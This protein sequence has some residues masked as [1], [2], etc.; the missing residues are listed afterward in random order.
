MMIALKQKY[1]NPTN[2]ELVY[3]HE[4]FNDFLRNYPEVSE[5]GKYYQAK[6][7]Y[8]P[9]YYDG[10][11]GELNALDKSKIGSERKG[12]FHASVSINDTNVAAMID[13]GANASFINEEFL[14]KN[15]IKFSPAPEG[16]TF[17]RGGKVDKP[18]GFVKVKL[19]WGTEEFKDLIFQVIDHKTENVILGTNLFD[20]LK[21]YIAGLPV[22]NPGPEVV[23][24]NQVL[25]GV[26]MDDDNLHE[27]P[28][29]EELDPR[30]Q[31]AI[32]RNLALD[33]HAASTHP[34][35]PLKLDTSKE[36]TCFRPQ[37]YIK[38]AD[39]ARAD[40]IFKEYIEKGILVEGDPNPKACFASL[41]VP[42]RNDDGEQ[43]DI[44][45]CFDLGP[46]NHEIHVDEYPLPLLQKILDVA[47]KHRGP[48]TFRS[49]IDLTGAFNV[50]PVVDSK[51]HTKWNG[52]MY[53]VERGFFGVNILPSHFQRMM[54]AINREHDFDVETYLDDTIN[55]GG[56]KEQ[57]ILQCIEI[58]N[59]FTKYGLRIN[60]KKC[61]FGKSELP[62]L[63][64]YASGNGTRMNPAKVEA[65]VNWKPPKSGLEIAKF[66]GTVNF[67]RKHL[68]HF[69]T[70]AA[71]LDRLRTAH[72]VEW[73]QELQKCFDALKEL[74]IH[75]VTLVREDFTKTP[76]V[77]TDASTE[78][79][80]YWRGQVKDQFRHIPTKDLKPE[81]IEPIEF[82]SQAID[83]KKA[84]IG[85]T[86]RELAA[87]VLALRKMSKNLM[88]RRFAL[89]TDHQPLIWLFNTKHTNSM[90]HRYIDLFLTMTFDVY[91][92]RGEDNIVADA[93]SRPTAIGSFV[94]PYLIETSPLAND[95]VYD[96]PEANGDSIDENSTEINTMEL[97]EDEEE[98]EEDTQHNSRYAA[99]MKDKILP[100]DEEERLDIIEKAHTKGHMGNNQT[101]QRIFNDGYWW[102]TIRA[103]IAKH[104]GAC[105]PCLRFTTRRT[106]YHPLTPIIEQYPGKGYCMDL[107]FLSENEEDKNVLIVM[108]IATG[109]ILDLLP[110]NTK[111]AT[112]IADELW[113]IICTFGPPQY[114]ISDNGREFVNRIMER[115]F[116]HIGVIHRTIASYHP[117]ANG[118]VE[119]AIQDVKQMLK[120]MQ[121]GGRVLK[122]ATLNFA[123]LCYNTH[124][125]S[126]TNCTP[127]ALMLGREANAFANYQSRS[128]GTEEDT[129][130]IKDNWQKM[131]DNIYPLINEYVTERESQRAEAENQRRLIIDPFSI[132]SFVMAKDVTRG[133]GWNDK[134]LGPFQVTHQNRNG[135]YTLMNPLRMEEPY[136]FPP[137]HLI[138][139]QNYEFPEDVSYELD[140]ILDVRGQFPNEEYLC[141]FRDSKVGN[142]WIGRDDF[143][144]KSTL[145]K[146]FREL[147]EKELKEKLLKHKIPANQLPPDTMELPIQ[148]T[149]PK[150]PSTSDFMDDFLSKAKKSKIR[151]LTFQKPMSLSE[152]GGVKDTIPHKE[153]T[154]KKSLI[155]KL[156]PVTE[157]QINRS[158]RRV[159]TGISGVR[160]TVGVG[161]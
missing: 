114:V 91:H 127:F 146:Y 123:K 90:L 3:M 125:S 101:F 58:I 73:T 68:E 70:I 87:I 32:K 144:S 110:S 107:F 33:P 88:G 124:I 63:G 51:I 85:T 136:R 84:H 112:A 36:L 57:D 47:T 7:S 46:V 143:D 147:R 130:I 83:P 113:R 108:D 100:V 148:S 102:P 16:M 39:R 42:K 22:K 61:Y 71:P 151:Q 94:S 79:L 96:R 156:F 137:D 103:D 75:N 12:F 69:A 77:F 24:I 5:C 160:S 161:L 35:A 54:D 140:K 38:P 145:I 62:V 118:K 18:I 49:K 149:S 34:L 50:C 65:I 82:G 133:T 159:P 142:A 31:E 64:Y 128:I 28:V 119:R 48:N 138:P 122:G 30:L 120:K 8:V 154:S 116:K 56:S 141:K 95:S 9:H 132:G 86:R 106:G 60:F 72:T 117:Q 2:D 23:E 52:K 17:L 67:N 111:S 99:F 55:E 37:T 135:S 126:R 134:Y 19:G 152:E 41:A 59:T 15:K 109:F 78:G 6:P 129:Q 29:M 11:I 93:L 27:P 76:L 25:E 139:V 43:T 131:Y 74:V 98:E 115:M 10:S 89:F 157:G 1:P 40:E 53:R 66:M 92:I 158:S 4:Y 21:I 121:E 105:L 155:K 20:R 80:G 153:S 13:C 44:R 97:G 26:K 45:V 14:K 81:M 104:V 150:R